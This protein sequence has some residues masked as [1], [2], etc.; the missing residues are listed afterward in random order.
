[1]NDKH[2]KNL[3]K[4]LHN[5]FNGLVTELEA[6]EGEAPDEQEERSPKNKRSGSSKSSSRHISNKVSPPEATAASIKRKITFEDTYIHPHKRVIIKLAILLKS[7]KAFGEFTKALMAFIENA[8]MVDLRFIINM[9]NPESK[10][11]GITSKGEISPNMTKLGIHVKIAGNGNTFNKQKVWDKK[12]QGNNGRNNRKS[13][14]KEE[15][16]DPIV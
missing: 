3:N 15:Y 7:D 14:N 5:I 10:E 11:K 13:K 16:R 12:E 8:Q 1:M 2:D 6:P 9:L 4:N